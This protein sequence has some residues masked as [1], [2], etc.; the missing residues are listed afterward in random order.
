[1]LS[2]TGH[3]WCRATTGT[4]LI[5]R[6][7][8]L[9]VALPTLFHEIWHAVEDLL[10]P[11]D[12]DVI[13]A[14]AARGRP[15]EGYY[16]SSA[17]ERRARFAESAMMV[18]EEGHRPI[19]LFGIPLSRTDRI[20][21]Y[22]HNGA[23]ARDV[24]AGKKIGPRLFPGQRMIRRLRAVYDDVGW[25]GLLAAGFGVLFLINHTPFR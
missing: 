21:A 14:A 7:A 24:A 4:I 11:E 18:F 20:I 3:Q 8:N 17:I 1:V 23:L 19:S 15:Y 10:D 2:K 13:N 6:Y 25:Q 16:L 12:K 5:A 9:S 22:V